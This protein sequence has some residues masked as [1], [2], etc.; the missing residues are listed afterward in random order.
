[1]RFTITFKLAAAFAAVAAVTLI[2]GVFGLSR[3]SALKNDTVTVA[4][5]LVPAAETVGLLKEETGKYRRNQ[6]IFATGAQDLD[7]VKGELDGS[8]EAV[9]GI[10]ETY[11]KLTFDQGAREALAGFEAAWTTYLE[12]TTGMEKLGRAERHDEALAVSRRTR[13]TPAGARSRTAWS[14]STTPTRRPPRT[15][16]PVRP[17]APIPRGP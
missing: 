13:A 5:R 14:R 9:P 7:D 4:E 3:T 15:S 10:S 17:T 12:A 16:R 1:M 2:L 8:V 6:L 11:R